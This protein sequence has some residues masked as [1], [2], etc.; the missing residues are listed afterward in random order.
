MLGSNQ[1]VASAN[2]ILNLIMADSFGVFADRLERAKDVAREKRYIIQDTLRDHGRIIFNGDNYSKEWEAE[3]RRRDLPI[4]T[5]CVD[6]YGAL[7][8]NWNVE[9]FEKLEVLTR[10]ECVSRYDVLLEN[11]IKVTEIEARTLAHMVRGSV[12]PAIEME[13]GRQAVAVNAL[14]TSGVGNRSMFEA[15][16]T[17]AGLAGR[18]TDAM[19]RLD[20]TIAAAGKGHTLREHAAYVRDKVLPAMEA[21]RGPCDRA[22]AVIPMSAWPFPP[23]PMG[24]AVHSTALETF[25][26]VAP[27]RVAAAPSPRRKAPAELQGA[28]VDEGP[29]IT[30]VA[31]IVSDPQLFSASTPEA[32]P[33]RQ[34]PRSYL[35][36]APPPAPVPQLPPPATSS[37][38]FEATPLSPGPLSPKRGPFSRYVN[39]TAAPP[40][41]PREQRAQPRVTTY[42]SHVSGNPY[43]LTKQPQI[44]TFVPPALIPSNPYMPPR[45]GGGLP[46]SISL[47]TS[48]LRPT[49]VQPRVGGYMSVTGSLLISAYQP[50]RSSNVVSPVAAPYQQLGQVKRHRSING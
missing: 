47:N 36:S 33:E 35:E 14:R 44:T 29:E 9:L 4:Y 41:N 19:D 3:A 49:I 22:E 31:P 34:A 32:E 43:H 15:F 37:A 20:A 12:L 27:P 7:V 8:A 48:G 21:V 39:P 26:P 17:L 5:S 16:D 6:A 50:T 2:T 13:L 10:D 40:S 18:I 46:R 23:F 25:I 1:S 24:V 30:P 28:P 45:R 11:Y 42:A 38:I